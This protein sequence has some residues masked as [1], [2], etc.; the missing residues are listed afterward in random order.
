MNE[1]CGADGRT[2]MRVDLLPSAEGRVRLGAAYSS[3]GEIR[4][5]G[6]GVLFVLL[7]GC[8]GCTFLP[9]MLESHARAKERGVQF[10]FR[11]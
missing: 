10:Y 4:V 5:Q 11:S 3:N 1:H 6:D 9:G 8:A 2:E 7:N